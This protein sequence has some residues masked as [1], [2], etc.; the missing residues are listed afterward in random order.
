MSG[1]GVASR[2]ILGV[3]QSPNVLI[4]SCI[5][6]HQTSLL[7]HNTRQPG[8]GLPVRRLVRECRALQWDDTA[9]VSVNSDLLRLR[10]SGSANRLACGAELLACSDI[11]YKPAV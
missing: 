7:T 6:C 4:E 2:L 10:Q 8:H 5:P 9:D 3:G 1:Y 11:F